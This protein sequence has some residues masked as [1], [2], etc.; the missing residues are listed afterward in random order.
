[1]EWLLYCVPP[2]PLKV[3]SAASDFSLLF[4]PQFV[5]GSGVI[6]IFVLGSLDLRVSV[7]VTAFWSRQDTIKLVL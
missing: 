4:S 3:G 6:R 7:E 1:M 5:S 2:C